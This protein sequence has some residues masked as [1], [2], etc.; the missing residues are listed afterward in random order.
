[1]TT[2]MPILYLPVF[3]TSFFKKKK[4]LHVLVFRSK[5]EKSI[6]VLLF[7]LNRRINC[8]N[9]FVILGIFLY[10]LVKLEIIPFNKMG[11]GVTRTSFLSLETEQEGI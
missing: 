10:D 4:L 11:C 1:M 8:K 6:S 7:L 9:W 2:K 5:Y 3:I